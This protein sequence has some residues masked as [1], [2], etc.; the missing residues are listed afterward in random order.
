MEQRRPGQSEVIKSKEKIS[1]E[2]VVYAGTSSRRLAFIKHAFPDSKVTSIPGGKEED[3]PD[4]VSIMQAKIDHVLSQLNETPQIKNRQ[5]RAV[6]IAADTRTS[7]LTR[8]PDN[9]TFIDSKGKPKEPDSVRKT[10]EDMYLA[11]EESGVL[12]FYTVLSGSGVHIK[13]RKY[14]ERLADVH[15]CT[16][17][18]NSDQIK[19]F[20]TPEGYT[21]YTEAFNQ[22]YSSDP[23]KKGGLSGVRVDDLSG[24][25]SLPVL[26]SLGAVEAVD[27]IE[28]NSPD[29]KE[30]F[31]HGM[32]TVSVGISP[33]ILRPIQ[34]NIDKSLASWDWLNGVVDHTLG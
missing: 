19:K 2:L 8:N 20:S 3:I 12:P 14:E 5:Q 34:P 15:T 22:F 6:I 18:L 23:Y 31:R 32:Y 33:H 1:P 13:G 9:F 25:L 17:E 10:F 27:G 7:V 21:E 30:A 26:T 29:F 28:R 24:G 11:G 4:V 16:V